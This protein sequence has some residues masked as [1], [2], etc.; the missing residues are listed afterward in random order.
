V[1]GLG[2]GEQ[3]SVSTVSAVKLIDLAPQWIGGFGMDKWRLVIEQ[4]KGKIW[5]G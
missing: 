5:P 1:W 2:V 3:N 4:K